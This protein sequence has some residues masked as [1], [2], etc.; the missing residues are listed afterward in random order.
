MKKLIPTVAVLFLSFNLFAQYKKAGFFEKEGRTYELSTQAYMMGKGNG[1]PI[2]YRLAFGR[3]KDGKNLFYSWDI[4]FIPSHKYS[5]ATADDNGMPVTV[6]GESK[7]TFVYGL[8][9]GYH[10]LKNEGDNKHTVQPFIS[11]GINSLILSG[12]KNES[13]SPSSYSYLKRNTSDQSF[14]IG[15]N[16]GL[17]CFFNLSSK[18]ALKVQGGY[19][20]Q[21]NFSAQ[22]WDDE[23]KPFFLFNSHTYANVGLRLR[24]VSE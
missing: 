15:L 8:N 17:G 10:L 23:V 18:F 11:A 3:D 12:I 7:S 4:Q 20:R 16:G 21:L 1:S 2:G 9:W 13:Y 14:S 22:N 5:Y 6:S 24:I 19:D